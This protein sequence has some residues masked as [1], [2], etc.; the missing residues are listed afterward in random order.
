MTFYIGINIFNVTIKS[1]QFN[2][3]R[4]NEQG[5]YY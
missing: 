3:N 5:A 1:L 2:H 4:Q